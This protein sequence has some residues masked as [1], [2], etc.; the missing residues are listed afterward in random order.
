MYRLG[1]HVLV[2][3]DSDDA[4]TH[5][6]LDGA[7]AKLM[8][9]DPPYD[10]AYDRWSRP[11]SVDVIGVW[12]RSRSACVGR[13]TRRQVGR[14]TLLYSPEAHGSN[15]PDAAVLSFEHETRVMVAR[16]SWW[17]DKHDAIDRDVI[18]RSS[19]VDA[20][21]RHI[22]W[23]SVGGGGAGIGEKWR[24]LPCKSGLLCAYVPAGS[25]VYDPCAGSGSSLIAAISMVVYGEVSRWIRRAW[26]DPQAM[27]SQRSS[28]RRRVGDGIA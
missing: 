13:G 16:R 7:I 10:D 17:A 19:T 18:R 28:A 1:R 9:F 20:D 8:I 21:D 23:Q 25:V 2:C 3:G 5:A 11:E 15:Q 22:S 4:I 24:S 27:G 14:P 12:Y 6:A 26:A